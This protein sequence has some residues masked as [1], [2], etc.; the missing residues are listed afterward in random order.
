MHSFGCHISE[1]ID[2]SGIFNDFAIVIPV[3]L[4]VGYAFDNSGNIAPFAFEE[5]QIID[6][7][8]ILH[9]DR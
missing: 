6:Q 5:I 1:L 2:G 9:I 8:Q 4:A 3:L 7:M